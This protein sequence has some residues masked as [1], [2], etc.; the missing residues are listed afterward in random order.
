MAKQHFLWP[1]YVALTQQRAMTAEAAIEALQDL[2]PNMPVA[3]LVRA[4]GDVPKALASIHG[5]AESQ[6]DNQQGSGA[7]QQGQ[8]GQ[9]PQA[10][11]PA[12][13]NAQIRARASGLDR[14][15]TVDTSA[16]ATAYDPE[17][18]FIRQRFAERTG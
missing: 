9:S 3:E 18:D 1:A 16:P 13:F 15:V 5:N 4:E 11:D 10:P 7:I 12:D 14:S 2:W 6:G 17:Q 8:Q